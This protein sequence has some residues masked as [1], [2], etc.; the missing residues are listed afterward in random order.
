MLINGQNLLTVLPFAN[1]DVKPNLFGVNVC[2]RD[3]DVYTRYFSD[4]LQVKKFMDT[5]ANK[6]SFVMK[7]SEKLNPKKFK[8]KVLQDTI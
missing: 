2:L 4:H 5:L 8:E 6:S 1:M 7:K 3:G